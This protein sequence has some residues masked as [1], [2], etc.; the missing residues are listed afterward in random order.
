MVKLEVELRIGFIGDNSYEQTVFQEAYADITQ[1]MPMDPRLNLT[2]EIR[3]GCSGSQG[4]SHAAEMHF[5]TAAD[6]LIGPGCAEGMDCVGMLTAFWNTPQIVY[7]SSPGELADKTKYNTMARVSPTNA[8]TFTDV[9]IAILNQST[10]NTV[11]IIYDDSDAEVSIRVKYLLQSF[12]TVDVSI[13]PLVLN[14]NDTVFSN[15]ILQQVDSIR[16]LTRVVIV[17]MGQSIKNSKNVMNLLK[18]RGI[19]TSEFVILL[20]W[21]KR[22]PDELDGDRNSTNTTLR[23]YNRLI[24]RGF[25]LEH[26][27]KN[28]SSFSYLYDGLKLYLI[29]L[30]RALTSNNLL[31][32]KN[33]SFVIDRMRGITFEGASGTIQMDLNCDRRPFYVAYEVNAADN[34]SLTPLANIA[35]RAVENCKPSLKYDCYVLDIFIAN[36]KDW[37]NFMALGKEPLCGYEGSKCNKS[38]WYIIAG[39][40]C[41]SIIFAVIVL[42]AWRKDKKKVLSHLPWLV[43]IGQVEFLDA[44]TPHRKS[45]A[46]STDISLATTTN[47]EPGSRAIVFNNT[48][49]LSRFKQLK[50]VTF[51]DVESI[52]LSSVGFYLLYSNDGNKTRPVVSLTEMKNLVHDNINPLVGMCCNN[53]TNELLVLWKY[54]SRGTLSDYLHNTEMRMDANFKTAFL[55]DIISGLEYLHSSPFGYHGNLTTSNCVIDA[56][57]IVKIV[58]VGVE[59]LLDEW[60]KAGIIADYVQDVNNNNNT[61]AANEKAR[62]YSNEYVEGVDDT[63]YRAPEFLRNTPPTRTRMLRMGKSEQSRF[64]NQGRVAD[65]Y[66]LAMVMYEVLFRRQP[67]SEVNLPKKAV[68]SVLKNAGREPMR[69]EFPKML[70]KEHHPAILSLIKACWSENPVSRPPV[71][72]VKKMVSTVYKVTGGLVASVIAMMDQHAHSLEKQVKERTRLLEE[73]QMRADRLLSQMIPKDVARDLKLG[74][75][76]IPRSFTSASVLFTDI[77]SFTNICAEST[78]VEIVNFLNDLFTGYDDI[79]GQMDAFKVET[80]G[81]AYMVVSGAPKENGTEHAN[82]ISQIALKMRHYLLSYKLPHMPE[83]KMQARWGMHSGPLAAGVVGLTAPRYCLF[84][85]TVNMASRMESSGEPEKI[86]ISG[87]L[88]DLLVSR[89]DKLCTEKRGLIN[90]KGKGEKITYWLLGNEQVQDVVIEQDKP[91]EIDELSSPD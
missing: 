19:T 44:E 14:A 56:N 84:G 38:S 79:I 75:P 66:S 46:S 68:I 42:Y 47:A 89:G 78:P 74:K 9:I 64:R 20:P 57:F 60:K 12:A 16:R 88:H 10:W 17:M 22:T 54:C 31:S 55:R 27:M 85:D 18:S 90:V 30:Q 23:F 86:Q 48:V 59:D 51:G 45:N 25:T 43:P 87:D 2:F 11:S 69:P 65:V 81:D 24:Q 67:F 70:G 26:E 4:L 82:V 77:V 8:N 34:T 13:Q 37:S 49:K 36:S 33:T 61:N 50:T 91:S 21:L 5:L 58:S 63:L 28:F 3:I 39:V 53:Q 73:A 40:I 80:I 35:P 6:A 7:T 83:H 32:V 15:E 62:E 72:K 52:L 41:V 1:V 29:G 71:K 76:V